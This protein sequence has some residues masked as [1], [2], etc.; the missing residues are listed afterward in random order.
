MCV[1]TSAPS[2]AV[3]PLLLKALDTPLAWAQLPNEISRLASCGDLGAALFSPSLSPI[4][5]TKVASTITASIAEFQK[6]YRNVGAEEFREMCNTCMEAIA[7]LPGVDLLKPHRKINVRYRNTTLQDFEVDN[8]LEETE[9]RLSAWL[10]GMSIEQENLVAMDMEDMIGIGNA[11]PNAGCRI[12]VVET[13]FKKWAAARAKWAMHAKAKALLNADDMMTLVKQTSAALT[14]EDD[15]WRVEKA[16]LAQISGPAAETRMVQKVGEWFPAADRDADVDTVLNAV[17]AEL[18]KAAMKFLPVEVKDGLELIAGWLTNL[19]TSS[20]IQISSARMVPLV[21]EAVRRM[22]FFLR[23]ERE[24]VVTRGHAAM[25]LLIQEVTGKA[26]Q[27]TAKGPDLGEIIKFKWVVPAESRDLVQKA[28]DAAKAKDKADVN[29]PAP[30]SA[31][32]AAAGGA[33]S[34]SKAAAGKKGAKLAQSFSNRCGQCI[35]QS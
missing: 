22:P 14:L 17:T 27:N 35:F 8:L 21:Q 33:S 2:L 5:S 23:L 11:E 18:N 7:A 24:A 3:P 12:V 19:K 16:V 20:P 1:P 9:T 28:I 4:M 26:K 34:S 25:Q 29:M 10:K 30:A 15:G 32:S 31:S 6:N 13:L